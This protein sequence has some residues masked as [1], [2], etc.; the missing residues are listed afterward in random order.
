[1]TDRIIISIVVVLTLL[2]FVIGGFVGQYGERKNAIKAGVA[3]Y[4]V[5]RQTGHVTFRYISNMNG[6]GPNK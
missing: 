3:E 1:M 2:L 5:D 6:I 4:I